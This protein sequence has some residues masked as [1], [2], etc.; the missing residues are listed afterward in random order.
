MLEEMEAEVTKFAELTPDLQ[1]GTSSWRRAGIRAT[2][3]DKSCRMI[4]IWTVV[5][6]YQRFEQD[7]A[8][9]FQF[10]GFAIFHRGNVHEGHRLITSRT[11][12][13]KFV[14]SNGTLVKIESCDYNVHMASSIVSLVMKYK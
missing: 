8:E 1:Y 11:P 3:N 9:S 2:H 14:K 6:F 13:G 4:L 10:L 12:I 7:E 5:T